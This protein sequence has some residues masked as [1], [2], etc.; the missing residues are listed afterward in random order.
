MADPYA[1][2]AD[3]VTPA[4]PATPPPAA[5]PQAL[6]VAR[7]TVEHLVNTGASKE[8][9]TAFMQAHGLNESGNTLAAAL[10]ARAHGMKVHIPVQLVTPAAPAAP[11]ADPYAEFADPLQESSD[12]HADPLKAHGLG[13]E[14][15]IGARAILNGAAAL[16]DAAAAFGHYANPLNYI[17]GLE[18]DA[19]KPL[20]SQGVNWLADKTGLATPQTDN[21]HL[22][23][24][25]ISGATGGLLTAPL[26]GEGVVPALMSTLSGAGAGG[27]QELARQGGA[28][29]M[30]QL[31]AGV[32]GGFAAPGAMAVGGKL[33]QALPGMAERELSP[34][35][36]AFHDQ[37]VPALPADVGGVGTRMAT[38][39]AKTTLGGLPI[40]DAAQASVEAARAARSRI[41]G[42][43]G[44][45]GNEMTAGQAAQAGANKFLTNSQDTAT[46]LY[47]AIPIA[48]NTSTKL[49]NT[50]Q[51]LT[52]ITRGMESN[53]ELSQLWAEFPRLRASLEAITPSETAASRAADLAD[54][55]TALTQAQQRAALTPTPETQST[56]ADARQAYDAQVAR[57]QERLQD[58]SVSWDDLKRLRSTVGEIIGKP[59]IAS[60]G[61]VDAAMRNLYGALSQDMQ[62]TATAEGPQAAAAFN[63]ANNFWRARQQRI[64]DVITP[65]LGK[66]GNA[67]PESAFRTIQAWAGDKGSFIRTAQALRSMPEEEASTVRATIFDRLGNAP[68]GQQGA[69]G[70][71][72]SPSTFLTQWNRIPRQ[73]KSVLFPGEQYQKDIN[74]LVTI[75]DAQK[76]AGKYANTSQTATAIH[77]ANAGVH[78]LH[79]FTDPV[80]TL[81]SLGGQLATGK[82]LSSPS[83]ARWLASSVKKPNAAAQLAHIDRLTGLAAKQ[84]VIANDV[85]NLQSRLR[86]AFQQSPQPLAAQPSDQESGQ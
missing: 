45:V 66:D 80:G 83:F 73:A 52:D 15:G 18:A 26:G 13:D 38:A 24:A 31:A 11:A 5:D 7:S 35:A 48:A 10:A 85:L 69:A 14:L 36:Q 30:G 55:Q 70:D 60:E 79:L 16:P 75:A 67:T 33:A 2:L 34:V 44:N 53:P 81:A 62:A 49:D 25:A 86:E 27:A 77:L 37:N 17:P 76:A 39:A 12:P 4:A 68:A 47:E 82:L 1:Q 59:G 46:K 20:A 50:R 84:P 42:T 74:D 41:A 58:G 28:G 32:A 3:P 22:A 8:Q 51:A 78:I 71:A 40:H 72:F 64:A 54:A 63:R 19:P 9:I 61:H 23:S 29:P 21:E 65:I 43:I 56:L 57:Q 6:E